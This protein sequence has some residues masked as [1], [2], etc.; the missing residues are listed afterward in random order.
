MSNSFNDPLS[1]RSLKNYLRQIARYPLLTPEEERELGRRIQKGDKEALRKLIESNLRFVVS[2]VKRYQGMGLPLLDLIHE[3]NLG[4]RED[5]FR[6]HVPDSLR[7]RFRM[8]SCLLENTRRHRI[9]CSFL[10]FQQVC[11]SADDKHNTPSSWNDNGHG[12]TD[13]DNNSHLFTHRDKSG[14]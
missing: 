14:S 9:G 13:S 7:L 5:H 10:L 1:S 12:T 4:F 6:R 2:Y 11:H 3:G 8:A